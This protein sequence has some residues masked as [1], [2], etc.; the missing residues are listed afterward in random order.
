MVPAEP[1]TKVVSFNSPIVALLNAYFG[2]LFANPSQTPTEN[3]VISETPGTT[4]TPVQIGTQ[5]PIAPP[6]PATVGDE[7]AALHA[8]GMGFGVL[9]KLLDMAA[10]SKA[11]CE[12]KSA[13][14]DAATCTPVTLDE[15][16]TAFN[17]GTGM[18]ELMK[19]YGRPSLMGVGQV[20]KAL[21]A[22]QNPD[23][24]NDPQNN[25]GKSN[26]KGKGKNK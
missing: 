17:S 10:E 2:E 24:V 16:V 26:G 3:P 23:T 1:E 4:E 12:A 18:G 11:T 14:G 13:S 25:H 21:K 20:R 5:V 9:V 8:E 19:E 22:E 6:V 15:L 7:V